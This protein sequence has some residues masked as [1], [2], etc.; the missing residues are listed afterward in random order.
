MKPNKRVKCIPVLPLIWGILVWL[1]LAGGLPLPMS[2]AD[3][4]QS[5]FDEANRLYEKGNYDQALSLYQR[6]EKNGSHWKLFY[7]TGNCYFKLGQWVQAKIYY[8]KAKRLEPFEPAIEKNI[9]IV[10]KRLNDKIVVPK[11]DFITRLVLRL[12]SLVSLNVLS[13]LLFIAVL[14]FNAFLFYSF[15]HGK[16]RWV[17]YGIAFSLVFLVLIAGYH[18]YRVGKYQ[19]RNIAVITAAATPLRSGPGENNTI[20]FK[21]N[22]GLEVRVI[23]SSSNDRWLQVSA[24]ADIAGWVEAE[25][26]VRIGGAQGND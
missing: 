13:I 6:I 3:I 17:M 15:S 25:H 4:S 16:R 2:A 7:N 26:L 14:I 21:V 12:E 8:L 20:L 5:S 24:S 11:P 23:G 18:I 22:S 9:D 10:N 19:E 1:V